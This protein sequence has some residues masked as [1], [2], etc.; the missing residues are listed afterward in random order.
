MPKTKKADYN[1]IINKVEA[2]EINKEENF[3]N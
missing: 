1:N 3:N 2:R